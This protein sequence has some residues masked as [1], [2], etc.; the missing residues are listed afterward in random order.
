MSGSFNRSAIGTLVERTTRFT[1]LVR[2]TGPSRAH[3]LRN[4][5]I[6]VFTELAEELRRSLTWDQGVELCPP[7]E[8]TAATRMPVFFCHRRRPWERPSNEN[9]NGLLRDSFPK[10]TSLRTHSLPTSLESVTS[11]TGGPRKTRGWRTPHDV[12]ATLRT[13]AV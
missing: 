11:S 2:L 10:S 1:I 12:F 9:T 13:E 6:D 5:L 7:R 3:S 8:I 4:E